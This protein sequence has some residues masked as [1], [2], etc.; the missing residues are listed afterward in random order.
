MWLTW[1]NGASW[2]GFEDMNGPLAGSLGIDNVNA[3][4]FNTIGTPH[5]GVHIT[6]LSSGTLYLRCWD[7]Y[8]LGSGW[9]SQG[10]SFAGPV[11]VTNTYGEAHVVARASSNLYI[12]TRSP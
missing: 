2:Q 11:D 9:D 5:V 10:S 12:R 7:S 1:W 3:V 8:C 4:K 6:A